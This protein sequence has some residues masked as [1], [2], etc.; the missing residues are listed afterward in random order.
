MNG[1]ID[2]KHKKKFSNEPEVEVF[3]VTQLSSAGYEL[4]MRKCKS[5]LLRKHWPSKGKAAKAPGYPDLLLHLPNMEKPVCVWENKGPDETADTAVNEAQFYVEGIRK[6]L[7]NEPGLPSIAVGYNGKDLKITYFTADGKWVPV[8]ADGKEL[9][10]SF[11]KALLVAAGMT[12]QG[13]FTAKDGSATI[14]DLRNVLPKLKTAYRNIVALASGRAP[15]DF[16]VALLTLKLVIEQNP[17]W[18]T[19]AEMPRFSPGSKS[20]DQAI[21]ERLET[22]VNRA[23]SDA[24][25]K[26]KYGDIFSFHEKSDNFEVAFSFAD[27]LRGI[28]K[29]QEHFTKIHDLLNQV[30]P[31]SGANF[32]IFGE[33]YQSIGDEA[34]KKKLGEFFTGRHI[35]SGVLPILFHRAGFNSSF[36]S[37]KSKKIADIACGTGGFLTEILRL[38]SKLHS[39]KDAALK[40]FAKNAFY[41][42]DIAQ[43]NASRARVNMYFAGDGF[44]S[45]RGGFDT[46]S[47]QAKSQF[48]A[49]GF[50]A[51]ATNPPYGL[52]KH[53]RLE[54]VF[55]EKALQ[56]LKPGTGWLLIVLPT[57]VL[58]NPRSSASRFKLLNQARITD[59]ISLPKHAFAPYTQQRTAVVIAQKRKGTLVADRARWADLLAKTKNEKISMYIVDHDGYANSDKRYPTDRRDT[60]GEWL[61]NDLAKWVDHDELE[62]PSKIFSSLVDQVM[63]AVGVDETGEPIGHKYG[64]FA[65][66][67]LFSMERGVALLPDIPLRREL[68]SMDLNEWLLRVDQVEKFSKG[69]AVV[70]QSSFKTEVEF[71][72]EQGIVLDPKD[73]EDETTVS[74]LFNVQ[75]GDTGLTEAMIYRSLSRDGDPIY[76]GGSGDARFKADQTLRR[77]TGEAATLFHGPATIVSMD[78]SAGSIQVIEEGQFYCNHH[79]AVL[80]PKSDVDL[81]C[82][83]Q[84]AEPALK[85][86]ASN[87]SGS[88]TLT[89]PSLSSLPLNMPKGKAVTQIEEARKVLTRLVRLVKG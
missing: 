67:D 28:E 19:W 81:W 56:A 12:A 66:G 88:A 9:K 65:P 62:Q 25:L 45:I 47:E 55:L 31:L 17:D 6:A 36:S 79:G 50:D 80:T 53:G 63:P 85:R 4:T 83:A 21:G 64:I 7:P 43:A 89:K 87:K 26:R 29:N 58:E 34:T 38:T 77:K 30:P 59:V 72:I 82:F 60:N 57:G 41:G 14:Q 39:P 23:M 69:E 37:I 42:F 78:G 40:S 33:V 51:V 10:D 70:L 3:A 61:H 86:L 18:G 68:R 24:E 75:K 35:I 49:T 13:S 44:S 15:I 5:A 32:D 52:S 2:F 71:L 73:R 48:P 76:G 11:P 8:K 46:L 1:L 74:E 22:L 16:T 54:E 84:L 20:I 27:T